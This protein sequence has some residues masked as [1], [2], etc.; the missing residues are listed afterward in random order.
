M[1]TTKNDAVG[2]WQPWLTSRQSS[3]LRLF[4]HLLLIHC[5]FSDIIIPDSSHGNAALCCQLTMALQMYQRYMVHHAKPTPHRTLKLVQ[6]INAWYWEWKGE[7]SHETWTSGSSGTSLNR[8]LTL[9]SLTTSLAKFFQFQTEKQQFCST[10]GKGSTSE[11]K[12]ST[13]PTF[14]RN[15]KRQKPNS[16]ECQCHL[17]NSFASFV[18]CWHITKTVQIQ[19][20]F[21]KAEHQVWSGQI[22]VFQHGLKKDWAVSRL[23]MTKD[24]IELPHVKLLLSM[25]CSLTLSWLWTPSRYGLEILWFQIFQLFHWFCVVQTQH[26]SQL[27]AFCLSNSDSLMNLNSIIS[28]H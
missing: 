14:L 21:T 3:V 22:C 9:T 28:Q 18:H 27:I 16:Q 15:L 4:Q 8:S 25:H 17:D 26:L 5:G 2:I 20:S 23:H 11:Q 7:L 1:D 13:T 19:L 10:Q 24:C 12:E 6:A